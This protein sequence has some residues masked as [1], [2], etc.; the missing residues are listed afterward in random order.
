MANN[1]K[2]LSGRRWNQIIDAVN[3]GNSADSIKPA[4]DD[5]EMEI[6]NSMDKKKREEDKKNGYPLYYSPV[7][8]E[9]DDKAL[10]IYNG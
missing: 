5:G 4:L 8:I 6:F 10:D 7:E 1:N 2:E 3:R 9:Y